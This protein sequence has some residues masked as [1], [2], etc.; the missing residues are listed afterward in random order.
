MISILNLQT[1]VDSLSKNQD[2]RTNQASR[3]SSRA[4]LALWLIPGCLII[5][6]LVSGIEAMGHLDSDLAATKERLRLI[7]YAGR[8]LL[9]N[10]QGGAGYGFDI[11][12]GIVALPDVEYAEASADG[13]VVFYAGVMPAEALIQAEVPP[14]VDGGLGLKLYASAGQVRQYA[15]AAARDDAMRNLLIAAVTGVVLVLLVDWMVARGLRQMLHGTALGAIAD[16]RRLEGT[17]LGAS[18]LDDIIGRVGG[19]VARASDVMTER[20]RYYQQV[21]DHAS[22]GVIVIDDKGIIQSFNRSAVEMFGYRADEVLDRNVSMLMPEPDRSRHDGYLHSYVTTNVSKVMGIGRD[23]LGRRKDGTV[24]PLALRMSELPNADAGRRFVGSV[25]DITERKRMEDAL[26]RGGALYRRA[27]EIVGLGHWAW[28]AGPDG[29]WQGGVSEYSEGAAAI[30][31]VKPSDLVGGMADLVERF[32]HPDD[33]ESTRLAY[34]RIMEPGQKGYAIDY[35]ILRPDGSVVWVLEIAETVVD[36]AGHLLRTMGT[37]QDITERKRME[38]ALR[39]GAALYHRAEEI[40][41]LGHW[42]WTAGPDGSWEGGVSE[43]SE[44]GAALFGVKPGDLAVGTT[45]LVERF[46]HPEDRESVLRAYAQVIEPGNQGYAV[47]YRAVRPGGSVAYVLEIGETVVDKD[48]R[49]LRT[50]GTLQDIT[51]RKVMEIALRES[52]ARLRAFL[53]NAPIGMY[54]KDLQGRYLMVNRED[55]HVFEHATQGVLGGS[56]EQFF[57]SAALEKIL[58]QDRE[59]VSSGGAVTIELHEPGRKRYVWSLVTK[60][61]ILGADGKIVAIG[62][63]DLDITDRKRLE[64]ALRESEARMREFLDNAP[65]VMTIKDVEGRYVLLNREAERIFGGRAEKFLGRRV[66]DLY[67]ATLVAQIEA[68]DRDVLTRG[69]PVRREFVFGERANF[70]ATLTTKFPIRDAGGALIGLGTI[71]LDIAAQKTLERELTVAKKQ[72]EMADRAKSDFLANM[73]HELR[74]PL[75]AVIGFSEAI[76]RGIGGPT[77][78]K[79]TEY[80][81]YIEGAGRHLLEIINDVLDMSRIEAGRFELRDQAIDL[82]SLV[83]RCGDLVRHQCET[84]NMFLEIAE[85]GALPSLTGDELALKKIVINLLSNAV[86]F[87][88]EGGR[89]SLAVDRDLGGDVILRVSDTG[90]GIEPEDIPLVLEPFRQV[91]NTLSRRYEGAG[92]GL[93]LA[94]SLTEL[95]GGSLEIDSVVGHGTTVRV[96]LPA[97]RAATH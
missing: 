49:L 1:R 26:R 85:M 57:E 25:R 59:V 29:S 87:T 55:E 83:E 43:Y 6:L 46:V 42:V 74:T 88:P 52:E 24:F 41:G 3:L 2:R 86:K 30:F 38:D 44:G 56:A 92:L 67:D 5:S 7:A 39:R 21:I 71:D 89:I 37:L 48:N 64:T 90:I 10:A 94:K 36:D 97:W 53:D 51:E 27:E 82:K 96:R 13:A 54:V 32:T 9:K 23:V 61:P 8:S 11:L 81:G 45:D 80:L 73:S 17:G 91:D 16:R 19:V 76:L 50:M 40:A 28:T 63:I 84:K 15:L 22:D 78:E 70:Q 60:F 58:A 34:A 62:G 14:L 65:M 66:S 4:R 75:N 69:E 47:E 77:T 79:Q 93:P 72:A 33:R 12:A 68:M 18:Q 35:R 95:H 20:E 31:G